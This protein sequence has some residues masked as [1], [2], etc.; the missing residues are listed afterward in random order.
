MVA[1]ARYNNWID[2]AAI[3]L[4]PFIGGP[5]ELGN[6]QSQQSQQQLSS[7]DF[8]PIGLPRLVGGLRRRVVHSRI[9]F[10]FV[11]GRCESRNGFTGLI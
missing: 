6:L 10:D 2:Q 3:S 5:S 8:G 9:R 7:H 1:A 4:F 11:R